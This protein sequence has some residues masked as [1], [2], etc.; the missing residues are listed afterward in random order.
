MV[1][2]LICGDIH[3]GHRAGLTHPDYQ[4]TEPDSAPRYRKKYE[5]QRGV[6]WKWFDSAIKEVRPVHT[7]IVNGDAV[8]G[9]SE[10]TGGTELLTRDR[11]EQADMAAMVIRHIGAKRVYMTFG[12][13]F[14]VGCDEDWE[15][16]VAER[17]GAEKIE[18]E[19]HYCIAGL[20]VVCRHFVGNSASPVSARTAMTGAQVKQQ[21]WHLHGQQPLANLMV[22]SHIHR[23]YGINDP[24]M[25]FQGWTT[26]ALQGLGTKYGSRQVDGLPVH[27]GFL[28][29]DINGPTDWGV[30]AYVAPLKL[31]AADVTRVG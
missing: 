24:A 19:G 1:R 23:C 12:T 10:R 18:A 15:G 20:H 14:H 5:E 13:P 4:T 17:V 25:N 2:V 6:L 30:T 16:I 9:K 29:A 7:L 27:F 21:L 3:A 22:R 11:D 26:P 28:V 8:D 31:Q